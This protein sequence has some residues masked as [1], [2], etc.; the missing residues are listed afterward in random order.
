MIGEIGISVDVQLFVRS[1][2]SRGICKLTTIGQSIFLF[3]FIATCET[4][5]FNF[6]FREFIL[7]IINKKVLFYF[8]TKLIQVALFISFVP[9]N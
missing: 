6:L 2:D 9:I 8:Q 7:K 5:I 4:V 1:L 3:I